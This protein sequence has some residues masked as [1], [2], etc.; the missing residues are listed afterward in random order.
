MPSKHISFADIKFLINLHYI[1]LVPYLPM[2]HDAISYIYL[3]SWCHD[4]TFHENILQRK[5][6]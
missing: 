5:S 4:S 6:V 2:C 3:Y 1:L